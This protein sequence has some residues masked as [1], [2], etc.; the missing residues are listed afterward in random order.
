MKIIFSHID[1]KRLF[2]VDFKQGASGSCSVQFCL[3][4]SARRLETGIAAP[5]V[6]P[7]VLVG[8]S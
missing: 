8:L 3:V 5:E 4:L 6:T 1:G 2:F 7:I